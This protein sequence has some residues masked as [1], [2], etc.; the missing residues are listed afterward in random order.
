M[1]TKELKVGKW[2]TDNGETFLIVKEGEYCIP[3]STFSEDAWFDIYAQGHIKFHCEKA[4]RK[5][6]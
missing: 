5:D 2:A 4:K 1:K 6:L 3:M